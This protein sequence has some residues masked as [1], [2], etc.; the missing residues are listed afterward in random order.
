MICKWC[1]DTGWT[2]YH[3]SILFGDI[4]PRLDYCICYEKGRI[5]QERDKIYDYTFTALIEQLGFSPATS[6]K[7]LAQ[8]RRLRRYYAKWRL[9]IAVGML[10][11]DVAA[12]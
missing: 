10:R 4:E 5:T 11:E 12:T 1:A 8:L 7:A 6:T 3:K 9:R 2:W